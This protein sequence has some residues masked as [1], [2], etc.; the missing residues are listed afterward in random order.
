MLT[1]FKGELSYH[2]FTREMVYKDMLSLRDARVQQLLEEKER[3]E[4]EANILRKE[5]IRNN[6]LAK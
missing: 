2:E 3:N 6:I 1:L 5:T 4:K